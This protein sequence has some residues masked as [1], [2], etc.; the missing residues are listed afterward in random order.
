MTDASS[1]PPAVAKSERPPERTSGALP[2]SGPESPFVARLLERLP[3]PASYIDADLVYRQCNAAAAATVGLRPDQIIGET[4]ASIVG[5]DSEVV[6]L[7]RGVLES[8]EPYSGTLEFTPPGSARTSQYR[9]SYV[10]DIDGDGRAVGILTNVVDITDLILSE[11]RFHSLFE[12]MTEGVALHELVY[13]DGLAV[14]YRI[15]E[16]NAAFEG[17]TG[18]AAASAQGRLASELYGTG[19]A[20]YLETYSQVAESGNAISFETYFEPM[21]RH[22]RVAVICPAPGR[23][24]TVFEDITVRRRAAEERERHAELLDL[25]FDAVIVW[26]LG[27]TIESWNRGAEELYGFSRAE[28]LGRVSQD[29]LSTIHQRPWPQIEAALREHGD[30]EGEVRHHARDGREIIVSS[31]H[32]LIRGGDGVERV[33]EINRDITDHKE[34]DEVAAAAELRYRQLVESVN[35]AILRWSRDGSVT[36]FN[37]FA[38]RLFGWKADEVLGRHV[39]FLLPDANERGEDLMRLAED[40]VADPERY[41]TNVNENVR[42]DGSRLWVAWTNRALLDERGEVSEVLA[43]GNDVSEL[44]AAQKALRESE[45]RLQIAQEAAALGVYDWDV[46]SGALQWDERVYEVWGVEHGE[47][48]TYATFMGGVHPADRAPTQ[49]AIDEALDPAGDGRYHVTYRV[50]N[51]ADEALHW[52]VATGNVVF[53]D[54]QAVR[55][56]G[57]IEDVTERR[58]TEEALRAKENEL[59][60]QQERSRLARDLHDS[61]TQALFAATL[62]AEALTLDEDSLSNQAYRAAEDVRRLSRG[63]LAQMRTMLLELRGDPP[64]QVPIAQLLRH[65]VEAAEGRASVDVQLTMRG[66]APLAPALHVAVYRIAQEALNNVTRHAK[67]SKAWVDLIMEPDAVR[68]VVGDDGRGYEPSDFDPGHMGLRLMRERAEEAGAELGMVTEL[69]RGT[70]VTVD[71][72]RG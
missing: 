49:A 26:Q 23:F 20:P 2:G 58:Q 21:E 68:L 54:G 15:L 65:L 9:V 50:V 32:Q 72:R 71:W 59:L 43:V 41:E 5:P 27:G 11:Q 29:L 19:D 18:I 55:L 36:L 8:G 70:V 61:V 25:S 56:V 45:R 67:A 69:G 42:K 3:Y 22:F 30:W 31:R 16:V 47:P 44:V 40:I 4:V 51:R 34:A 33:L 57:T 13:E 7:L 46:R 52:V 1:K 53:S 60:A 10:P 6:A 66:D 38:E 24:A 39:S 62:K 35:S 63:A 48:V 28:A 14:D 64:E 17:Q 37:E 12:S